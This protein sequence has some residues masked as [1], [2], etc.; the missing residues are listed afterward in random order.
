MD[1]GSY[2]QELRGDHAEQDDTL[3]LINLFFP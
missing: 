1:G 2:E 3:K